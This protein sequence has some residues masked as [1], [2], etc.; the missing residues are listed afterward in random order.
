MSGEFKFSDFTNDASLSKSRIT[1]LEKV[2]KAGQQFIGY[3]LVKKVTQGMTKKNDP[4][5]NV[6]LGKKGTQFQ[7]KL[8]NNAFQGKSVEDIKNSLKEGTV[9][10]VDAETQEYRQEIQMTIKQFSI[11]KA[12]EYDVSLFIES[13]PEDKDLLVGELEAYIHQIKNP[14]LRECVNQI[15]NKR[16]EKFITY[17]AASKMHHAFVSGLLY[18][19][20]SMLRVADDLAGRYPVLNRDILY[21]AIILHDAG[22]TEEFSEGSEVAATYSPEGVMMGH[23]TMAILY[24]DREEMKIKETLEKNG[25]SF[26]MEDHELFMMVKN[27][28]QSHHGPIDNGWGSTANPASIEAEVIHQ[29][30]MIDSRI[31][32]IE[33]A[34]DHAP[35]SGEIVQV[36]RN[37]YYKPQS[38]S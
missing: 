30:D 27:A 33:Q 38:Y 19:T 17:P 35:G 12:S 28:I 13:A 1:D 11:P 6:V 10:R 20:V 14:K 24:I 22:K 3:A 8:W 4:F 18:H 21:A 2:T 34:L 23:I 26:T 36:H 9:I 31:N 25:D 32:M 7:A 5:F 15:Y 37:R 16:K 29:I